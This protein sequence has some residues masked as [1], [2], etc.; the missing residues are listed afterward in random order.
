MIK[1]VS[2][3]P[4]LAL[5]ILCFM[6]AFPIRVWP[7]NVTQD[8]VNLQDRQYF[9]RV[10]VVEN[11]KMARVVAHGEYYLHDQ[12]GKVLYHN[13]SPAVLRFTC[14]ETAPARTVYYYI[15]Q[16]FRPGQNS[17]AQTVATGAKSRL[18]REIT[19]RTDPRL[20][21]GPSPAGGPPD[22]SM[23]LVAAVGPYPSKADADRDLGI[24]TV[25]Y[26]AAILVPA[27]ESEVKGKIQVYEYNK[28]ICEANGYVGIWPKQRDTLIR[29][30]A[31][32]S[33][34]SDWTLPS[35]YQ[36]D[37]KYRG[38]IEIWISPQGQLSIV[39]RVFIEHYIF[40]VLPGE[41]GNSAPVEAKRVQAVIA[42]SNTIAK[43]KLGRHAGQHFDFCAGQHC[44]VYNGAE[45]E[46]IPTNAAVQSTWG[47]VCTYGDTIVDAVYSQSCGGVIANNE[48]AWE[49]TPQPYMRARYDTPSGGCPVSYTSSDAVS[50]WIGSGASAFCNSSQANFPSYAADTFRWNR[51][52]TVDQL[53]RYFHNCWAGRS[54]S[55]SAI[56][57]LQV[58]QRST[59]GRAL[60]IIATTD[61][62][63]TISI[64]KGNDIRFV[65][66]SLPSSLFAL[67]PR[68]DSRH[69]LASVTISGAGSGHGV[70]VCQIG[71]MMMAN[72]GYD[73]IQI[74]KHYFPG[75][76]VYRIYK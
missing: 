38:L 18:Q 54:I 48:D 20:D 39:N 35:G 41:I 63:K 8:F 5:C 74:L 28:M 64:Q 24:V 73:Y 11:T 23:P 69:R 59:S 3:K 9:V 30:G 49:G 33:A 46:T 65:L 37:K 12:Q 13:A 15:L 66:G 42:R 10:G 32:S 4:Y 57:D 14:S 45:G 6:V 40:G 34:S 27:L 51:T 7:I 17:D 26:P 19:V 36:N 29:A 44:Q 60:V 31:L 62:G 16:S 53:T 58:A 2:N 76:D 50:G 72:K 68:Y 43:L 61:T 67:C 25:N 71:T 55:F 1:S 47:Q 75:V 52:Y 21:R 22:Q 56:T 70:G